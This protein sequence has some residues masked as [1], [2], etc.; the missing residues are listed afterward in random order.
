MPANCVALPLRQLAQSPT[1]HA[2]ALD[3]D[4]FLAGQLYLAVSA[5][6]PS[7]DLVER[8]PSALKVA[9]GGEVERLIRQALPGLPL[10]HVPTPPPAVPVKLG[11]QYFRLDTSGPR[12]QAVRQARNLAVHVPED[13]PTAQL[14]LV[15]V[16]P[17]Q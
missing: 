3:E 14:E 12:W 15:I 6:L 11:H 7:Q 10:T 1:V 8:A 9:S 17:P 5:Q 2:V 16:L 13:F 4:R